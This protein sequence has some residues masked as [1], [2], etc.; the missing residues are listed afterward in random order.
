MTLI[1]SSQFFEMQSAL[2]HYNEHRTTLRMTTG[3]AEL[4]SL[5]DAIEEGL[6]YLFYGNN[7]VVLDAMVY[8]FLV[9]YVFQ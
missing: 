4:D 5:T 3:S 6:F 7:S 8:R 2:E 9:N 1:Q